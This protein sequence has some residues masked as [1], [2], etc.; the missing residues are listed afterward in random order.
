MR[1]QDIASQWRRQDLVRGGG[2][3]NYMKLFVVH[4]MTRNNRLNKVRVAATE[5]T[6]LLSQNK[7]TN[8]L[9]VQGNHTKSLS[10]FVHAALKS[11]ETR[12]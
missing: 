10:D 1:H 5:L 3:Q 11:T 7:N 8:M 4:K 9:G 6:Q 2:A 12:G